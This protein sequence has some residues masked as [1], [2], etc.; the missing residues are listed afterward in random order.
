MAAPGSSMRVKQARL[1]FCNDLLATS[2]PPSRSFRSCAPSATQSPRKALQTGTP[3]RLP[4]MELDFGDTPSTGEAFPSPVGGWAFV[5]DGGEASRRGSKDSEP[6]GVLTDSPQSCGWSPSKSLPL[7]SRDSD[8]DEPQLEAGLL[9]AAG[10]TPV[11][12]RALLRT[13]EGSRC[14]KGHRKVVPAAASGAPYRA[15]GVC[16]ESWGSRAGAVP[17]SPRKLNMCPV[18]NITLTEAAMLHRAHAGICREDISAAFASLEAGVAASARKRWTSAFKESRL[19]REQAA[20]WRKNQQQQQ[21]QRTRSS[22]VDRG[23]TPETPTSR[24]RCP[25]L[26]DANRSTR[27][28]DGSLPT[29]PSSAREQR[30]PMAR[31]PSITFSTP[32]GSA[33]DHPARTRFEAPPS[34]SQSPPPR[35]VDKNGARERL[36]RPERNTEDQDD[37]TGLQNCRPKGLVRLLGGGQGDCKEAD[38]IKVIDA[39]ARRSFEACAKDAKRNFR[40]L[41]TG[42]TLDQQLSRLR[43]ASNSRRQAVSPTDLEGRFGSLPPDEIVRYLAIF[44]ATA[45]GTSRV[46]DQDLRGVRTQDKVSEVQIFDAVTLRECMVD[47]GLGGC[48]IEEQYGVFRFCRNVIQGGQGGATPEQSKVEEKEASNNPA[49]VGPTSAHGSLLTTSTR[50]ISLEAFALDIIPDLREALQAIRKRRVAGF[51]QGKGWKASGQVDIRSCSELIT[52]FLLPPP[53][54]GDTPTARAAREERFAAVGTALPKILEKRQ[55]DV[56]Q[57]ETMAYNE[58][59]ASSSCVAEEM[60]RQFHDYQR[61]LSA[62][63]SLDP[64]VFRRMRADL[65]PLYT[66]WQNHPSLRGRSCKLAEE[67]VGPLLLDFGCTAEEAERWSKPVASFVELLHLVCAIQEEFC[68]SFSTK[69]RDLFR[70]FACQ[71][72]SSTDTRAQLTLSPEHVLVFHDEADEA[73]RTRT[74]RYDRGTSERRTPEAIRVAVMEALQYNVR[75]E[76][77]DIMQTALVG[78]RAQELHL[79]MRR[80]EELNNGS[81]TEFLPHQLQELHEVFSGL[82]IDQSGRLELREVVHAIQK[83]HDAG[84]PV[85]ADMCSDMIRAMGGDKQYFNFEEF[86][87]FFQRMRKHGRG[88]LT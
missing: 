14:G 35:R 41:G 2:D 57:R 24:L 83:L 5:E 9:D 77:L 72:R 68:Q 54:L 55:Q 64:S 59:T 88:K 56:V 18:Q 76:A 79:R 12:R 71:C 43:L 81:K 63:L 87:R 44:S 45:Q 7:R 19:C 51:F 16:T 50:P 75:S 60:Q 17:P 15:K 73:Q 61:K 30:Q 47:L 29:P 69:H 36:D 6:G 40:R 86:L 32:P 22:Q 53:P 78:R 31:R 34:R 74:Q 11:R 21:G 39:D 52:Q 27:Q 66:L 23:D 65:I 62:Q 85:S 26:A 49:V 46:K 28:H 13:L 10:P 80:K 4:P 20:K 33:R 38:M 25:E 70:C 3:R 8:E 1:L 48:S 58:I 42:L 84:Y 82:D 67:E 37:E